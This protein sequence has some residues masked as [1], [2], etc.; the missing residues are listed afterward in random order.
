MGAALGLF[1]SSC[2]SIPDDVFT[3]LTPLISALESRSAKVKQRL[4][5]LESAAVIGTAAAS[6]GDTA[7]LPPD[8]LRKL[9]RIDVIESDVV[10]LFDCLSE[11]VDAYY[12][13]NL[14]KRFVEFRSLLETRLPH[15]APAAASDVDLPTPFDVDEAIELAASLKLKTYRVLRRE[16]RVSREGEF[17][18]SVFRDNYHADLATAEEGFLV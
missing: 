7:S 9:A 4:D 10:R 16:H 11:K 13:Y 12:H 18:D 2:A 5:A 3:K 14:E 15:V 17:G 8:V 6:S 1:Q